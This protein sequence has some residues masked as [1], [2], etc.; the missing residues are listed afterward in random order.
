MLLERWGRWAIAQHPTG[1][2]TQSVLYRVRYQIPRSTG[3]AP[4]SHDADAERIER[5]VLE[6]R[7]VQPEWGQALV[8]KYADK[9]DK[10]SKAR[11]MACSISKLY[12]L[13]E[14]GEAWLLGRIDGD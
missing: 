11:A 5:L 10:R 12:R 8:L 3:P 6:L 7:E 9:R 13:A 1:Y 4:E 2:P 14:Q